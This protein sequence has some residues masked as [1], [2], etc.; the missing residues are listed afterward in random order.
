MIHTNPV[1]VAKPTPVAVFAN[2]ASSFSC[3]I[4]L[5]LYRRMLVVWTSRSL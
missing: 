3:V 1:H 2:I 5:G 4:A